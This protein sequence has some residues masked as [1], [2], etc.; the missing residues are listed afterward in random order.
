MYALSRR[1]AEVSTYV[2]RRSVSKVQR[3]CQCVQTCSCRETQG[4]RAVVASPYGSGVPRMAVAAVTA[5]VT[6]AAM[7]VAAAAT[8]R[9]AAA[10]ELLATL[11]RWAAAEG[12]DQGASV[13]AALAAA[14][15]A[16]EGVVA[17]AA[18]GMGGMPGR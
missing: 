1:D 14:G 12:P 3:A 17:V 9:K 10:V 13:V 16:A 7:V 4:L 18:A 8:P 2:H 6:T 15:T 11:E 5:A